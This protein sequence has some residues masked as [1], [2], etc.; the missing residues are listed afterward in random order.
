MKTEIAKM[1][2]CTVDVVYNISR[3]RTYKHIYEKYKL[4]NIQR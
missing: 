2:N 3:G 1:C 4:G